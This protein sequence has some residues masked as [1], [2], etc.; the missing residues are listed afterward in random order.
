[1]LRITIPVIVW[2][3]LPVIWFIT[4]SEVVLPWKIILVWLAAVW[5]VL[6]NA[7]LSRKPSSQSTQLALVNFLI[8]CLFLVAATGW[9]VSPFFFLIN[10]M[11]IAITFV[12]TP[13]ASLGFIVALCVLYLFQ[14]P[15]INVADDALV[16]L[17]LI[18]TFP[19]ALYLRRQYL[20]SQQD[21]NRILILEGSGGEDTVEKI[22]SNKITNFSSAIRQPLVNIKNYTHVVGNHKLDTTVSWEYMKR[23]YDSATIALKE[24]A[25]FEEEVTGKKIKSST[26]A[27]K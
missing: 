22:L 8:F 14:V 21:E 23:I 13:L 16:I 17:S 15:Q 27:H 26:R 12:V 20:K 2:L 5:M 19:L 4:Q 24:L 25:Q 9:F 1:M 18:V 6:V 11:A 3:A 7:L 10:L